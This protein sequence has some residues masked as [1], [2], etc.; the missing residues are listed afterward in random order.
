MKQFRNFSYLAQ[1]QND[2]LLLALM[3]VDP[4]SE[5]GKK[6][7]NAFPEA[8]SESKCLIPLD[9]KKKLNIFD[10]STEVMFSFMGALQEQ[11]DKTL[12]FYEGP[13]ITSG[14]DIEDESGK[15]IEKEEDL[16]ARLESGCVIH[17]G[18]WYEVFCAWSRE[19]GHQG[20][21][22]KRF[23]AI[24]SRLIINNPTAKEFKENEK[25]FEK[26]HDAESWA[27]KNGAIAVK[28]Y[29]TNIVGYWFKFPGGSLA[30]VDPGFGLDHV[31]I[32]IENPTQKIESVTT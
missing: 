1:I 32:I 2:Y 22:D 30:S 26:Y 6:L 25:S 3:L 12:E 4:A 7:F 15:K 24:P 11:G 13:D 18:E 20:K 8:L 16:I 17:E 10:D 9:F 28:A 14:I 31:L 23:L 5:E 29:N 19:S 21:S 27:L